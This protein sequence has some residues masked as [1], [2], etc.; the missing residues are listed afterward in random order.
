MSDGKAIGLVDWTDLVS[1]LI[2]AFEANTD[3]LKT[4]AKEAMN[5]SGRNEFKT[6]PHTSTVAEIAAATS[7][8]AVARVCLTGKDGTIVQLASPSA[9]VKYIA[10]HG[11]THPDDIPSGSE[12]IGKVGLGI[13]DVLGIKVS[14]S[15]LHAFQLMA[16]KGVSSL[17]LI[18]GDGAVIGSISTTDLADL[19]KDLSQLKS[20]AHEFVFSIRRQRIFGVVP[21]MSVT[22]DDT[23]TKGMGVLCATSVRHIYITDPKTHTKIRGILSGHTFLRHIVGK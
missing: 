11:R 14:D 23:L 16:K 2:K 13:R 1:V 20:P 6:L 3:F 17:P 7:H 18:G 19:N 5:A 22:T 8:K 21:V 9:V 15:T 10:R 4:T 12:T